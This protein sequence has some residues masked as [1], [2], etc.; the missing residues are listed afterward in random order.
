[1]VIRNVRAA[2]FCF[3]LFIGTTGFWMFFMGTDAAECALNFRWS[4][5]HRCM[6]A[7]NPE[8]HPWH[9]TKLRGPLD[10][11]VAVL[12]L[13]DGNFPPDLRAKIV[14]NKQRYCVARNY[15]LFAPSPDEI[16]RM[17]QVSLGLLF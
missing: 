1:M 2:A 12:V 15:D 5:K 13:V 3:L 10:L 9:E 6:P 11:R 8:D 17:S 4:A 16:K 7:E 14:G